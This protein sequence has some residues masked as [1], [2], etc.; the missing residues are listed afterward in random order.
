[1]SDYVT[2]AK[3]EEIPEG[4]SR[5]VEVAGRQIALF[6]AD[7]QIYALD[8]VCPHRGGPLGEGM[9]AGDEVICPWH[10][11]SFKLAT[12]AYT[13]DPS[14][15]VHRFDVVVDDGEVKIRL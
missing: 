2:V 10:A 12:G 9:I 6:K 11:W 8:N 3:L 14:L 15:S 1:M 13:F 7:G 4:G 5:I